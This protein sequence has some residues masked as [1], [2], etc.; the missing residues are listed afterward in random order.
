MGIL[1]EVGGALEH[2]KHY[3]SHDEASKDVDERDESGR[4]HEKETTHSSDARDS[5]GDRHERG[6]EGRDDTP[7]S[8]A[9]NNVPKG[10]F[11]GHV[12]ESTVR[13]AHAKCSDG[14]QTSCV[15]QC[16]LQTILERIW[17][18]SWF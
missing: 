18:C 4:S 14:F 9:A 10:E 6:V 13:R 11:G 8:V 1:W 3:F 2:L 16:L 15:G 17:F 5:I 12:G 7:D